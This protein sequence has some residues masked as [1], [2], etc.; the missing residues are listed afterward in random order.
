MHT[1]SRVSVSYTERISPKGRTAGSEISV[2]TVDTESGAEG[3]TYKC[4]LYPAALASHL[5]AKIAKEPAGLGTGPEET[6]F[7]H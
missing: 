5:P 4:L 3:E 2:Q 1:S 7:H 6:C